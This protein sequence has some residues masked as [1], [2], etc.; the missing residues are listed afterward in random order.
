MTIRSVLVPVVALAVLGTG[1]GRSVVVDAVPEA[2]PYDGP[3]YVEVTAGPD[4]EPADRSGA[5]GRVVD[6]DS[7][8]LGG[9]DGGG[10]HEGEV[11]RTPEGAVTAAVG[12]GFLRLGEEFREARR[13]EDR[14]LY[15]YEVDRRVK[16][17]YVVHHGRS[18]DGHTGWY[19]ESEA[20]CDFAEF[21]DTVT[22]ELGLQ[23]WTD[24]AGRR[25]PTS[26]LVSRAGPEH[27]D[28]QRMTFLRVDGGDL[29]GGRTYVSQPEAWLY[30]DWLTEPYVDAQPL[31]AD[32]R[33]T[34]Y[35][36]GG[37]HLW[38]SA[39]RKRAYVGTAASVQSWPG[40]VKPLGCA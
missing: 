20:R 1:C 3:L 36:R 22:D 35:E 15:T 27:C 26:V 17:A 40:T 30:P 23:I 11:T 25:V 12:E 21:P 28:W 9:S 4:D 31:P 14:V 34:G 39:D 16:Q 37:D 8:V 38:T 29:D 13:E 5:A 2:P 24:A 6:C 19:V 32:A 18:I 33:D 7:A 10:P